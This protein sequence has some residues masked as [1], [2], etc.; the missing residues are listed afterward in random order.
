MAIVRT[1]LPRK[2]LVEPQHGVTQYEADMDG[3]MSLLDANVVFRTDP[4]YLP[5]A[6]PNVGN[7]SVAHHLAYVPVVLGVLLTPGVPGLLAVQLNGAAPKVDS[8]NVYLNSS[9]PG[10]TGLVVLL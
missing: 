3:N 2:G 4:I 9:A 8:V 5:V 6:A 1:V 7:F 10:V